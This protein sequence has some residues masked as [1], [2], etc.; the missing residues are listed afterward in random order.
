MH[1]RKYE[2]DMMR[3]VACIM[4]VIL[5]TAA[6][7]WNL[8]PT[9]IEWKYFNF[10]DMMVRGGVPLF[11]MISGALFI[12][13]ETIDVKML[14]YHNVMHLCKVFIMW[15]LFYV[16]VI[17]Q[18]QIR[19]YSSKRALLAGVIRGYDHLWFLPV[20][21]FVYFFIP[22][23][24]SCIH[25]QKIKIKYLLLLFAVALLKE[26]IM[27]IP[28]VSDIAVALVSKIDYYCIQYLGYMVLGAGLSRI[29]FSRRTGNI[30][31]GVYFAISAISAYANRWYAV[32]I[33]EGIASEWLYGN[34]ALPVV[35]QA[36]CIFIFF[37][38]L[39]NKKVRFAG[40]LAELSECTLGIYLL[41]PYIINRLPVSTSDFHP[42]ISIPYI[43]I[44]VF[45]ISFITIFMFRRI[46]IIKKILL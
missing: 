11:F 10:A 45:V 21:I 16:I 31:I 30:S 32:V 5:H 13:R 24:H 35:I 8:E 34:F 44:L 19:R 26:N 38:S 33:N 1:N 20:M 23:V 27:L 42:L 7:G 17:D 12:N 37:Q 46:P 9:S 15:S 3:I 2:L 41:H 43:F 14:L 22:I 39:K 6:S 28:N 25:E 4:V 18:L 29:E 40:V 36:T